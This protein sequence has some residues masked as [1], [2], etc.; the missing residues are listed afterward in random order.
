MFGHFEHRW[1][2]IPDP[3][4]EDPQFEN[5]P[6]TISTFPSVKLDID[7]LRCALLH[8]EVTH[9]ENQPVIISTFPGVKLNIDFLRCALLHYKVANCENQPVQI[10]WSVCTKLTFEIIF[11]R[12]SQGGPPGPGEQP[13]RSMD[14]NNIFIRQRNPASNPQ[15]QRLRHIQRARDKEG[16]RERERERA[17]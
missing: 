3:C 7:F 9:F 10:Y 17:R 15:L 1:W 5:E 8:H 12:K 13:D 16:E 14:R 2:R 6:V 11:V 4:K